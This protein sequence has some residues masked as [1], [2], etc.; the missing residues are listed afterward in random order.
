MNQSINQRF[1]NSI[2]LTVELN[3]RNHDRAAPVTQPQHEAGYCCLKPL[4]HFSTNPNTWTRSTTLLFVEQPIGTG[5]S[6]G[7]PLPETEADVGQDLDAFMQNFYK[8]FPHLH[9]YDF[10][11]MGESYAGMFVPSVTRHFVLENGKQIPNRLDIPVRGASLGNGWIEAA[12]QGPAVIDYSWWHG[13]IDKPTRDALHTEWRNCY[14][15][16]TTAVQPAPFHP[17]NVQDDCGTMW[18]VLKA[19]GYPNAYDV[20]T[21]DPNVDQVTFA[22]EAF[23][24]NPKVKDALHVTNHT[25]KMWHGCGAGAGRRKLLQH[26]RQL[27]MDND[28]PLSVVPYIADLLELD[29]PILIYNGDRDMTTNMVG[30]ELALN[31]MNWSGSTQWTDASRGLWMV[32]DKQ[33]GWAKELG[34][35]KFVTVY[36]SGHM[37]PYNVPEPA[38]DLLNRLLTNR[39]FVDIELPAVRVAASAAP[40]LNLLQKM[41]ASVTNNPK[42]ASMLQVGGDPANHWHMIGISITSMIVGFILAM[43]TVRRAGRTTEYRRIP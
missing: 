39:T 34:N 2:P 13:L 8:V 10:F 29:V 20:T 33:A 28:R 6:F 1:P 12:I 37:V 11:V 19:S 22:S 17:F 36:N 32:N 7:T 9:Q 35:L 21:W 30:T 43:I 23:Y 3:D 14:E 5:F 38:F 24:N 15:L 31:A 4:P 25:D 42:P 40:S 16:K 26:Q 27:Y 41:M 18:G